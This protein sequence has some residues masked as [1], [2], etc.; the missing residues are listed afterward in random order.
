MCYLSSSWLGGEENC[1]LK[2]HQENKG[3][4]RAEISPRH[5]THHN[6]NASSY[7]SIH[8]FIKAVLSLSLYDAL[9]HS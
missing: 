6:S 1:E 2:P 9:K 3:S 4:L 7:G 8:N 5:D